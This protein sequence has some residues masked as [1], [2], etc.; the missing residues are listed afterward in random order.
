[1][2]SRRHPLGEQTASYWG[3]TDSDGCD[4]QEISVRYQCW[5]R[6]VETEDGVDKWELDV[7]AI[8]DEPA[9]M[10]G[11]YGAYGSAETIVNRW[12]GNGFSDDL[13]HGLMGW[14]HEGRFLKALRASTR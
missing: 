10:G 11:V 6:L 9:F 13:V 7:Q 4:V 2:P 14:R 8:D 5:I 1:M 12:D 3:T